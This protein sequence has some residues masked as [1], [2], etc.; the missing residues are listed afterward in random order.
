MIAA[1]PSLSAL[2]LGAFDALPASIAI[3]GRDGVIFAVN[4]AW[5][6]FGRAN[7]ADATGT[8]VGVNYLEVARRAATAGVG[9]SAEFAAALE[10]ALAGDLRP[11]DLEYPCHSPTEQRWFVARL[12]PYVVDGEPCSL[13]IHD[14]ATLL[15]LSR[16]EIDKLLLVA[17]RTANGVLITDAEERVEWINDAVTDMT[18]YPFGEIQ[19]RKLLEFLQGPDA[20]RPAMDAIREAIKARRGTT[21]TLLH[22]RRDGQ[23]IWVEIRLD[24][25]FDQDGVL[26]HFVAVQIDVSERRRFEKRAERAAQAERERMALDLHDGLG[27]ELTGASMMLS[28]AASNLGK[29]HPERPLLSQALEA[30]QRAMVSARE[31]AHGLAPVYLSRGLLPALQGLAVQ[32]SVAGGMV[33]EVQSDPS[34]QVDIERAEQLYRISQEAL[35]NAVR[36]S[37]GRR[38]TLSLRRKHHRLTLR[39]ADDGSGFDPQQEQSGLGLLSMK[40]RVAGLGGDVS[41]ESTCQGGTEVCCSLPLGVPACAGDTF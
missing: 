15:A 18:G 14:S 21:A 16:E 9:G 28:A 41:V 22:Y 5:R 2:A 31:I 11:F 17:R 29:G 27:Q 34:I 10:R 8:D 35:A 20:D 7:G 3:L 40:H 19:G 1:R 30:L 38:I 23:P 24:P 37:R 6:E 32:M 12:R 33:I 36:H 26:R 4:R 13:V 39:I 25:V